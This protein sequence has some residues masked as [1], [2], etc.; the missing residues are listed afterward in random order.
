MHLRRRLLFAGAFACGLLATSPALAVVPDATVDIPSRAAGFTPRTVTVAPDQVVQWVWTGGASDRNHSPA[1][2]AGQAESW[3]SDPGNPKP[4]FDHGA[5]HTFDHAFVKSGSFTYHCKVHADMTG[6]IVVTGAPVPSYTVPSPS[7]AG[8]AV[9]FDASGSTDLDGTIAK[10][11]WDLDGNGTF[12]TD[13]GTTSSATKTYAAPAALTTRLRVTDDRGN[14]RETTRALTIATRAPSASFTVTPG[15]AA[16][17]Q[18]VSLDA[19]A[20]AATA[21]RT[22]ANYAWDLDGNGSFETDGGTTPTFSTSY[23]APGPKTIGLQVTDSAGDATATTR[24]LTVTNALP[25]AAFTI[26][27]AA[28][29]IGA[30]VTFD[31]TGSADT[32]GTIASF[33]WDLDGNGTFETNTGTTPTTSKAYAAAGSVSVK[34]RVTDNDGATTDLAKTVNVP[35]PAA[36]PAPPSPPAASPPAPQAQGPAPLAT[37]PLAAVTPAPASAVRPAPAPAAKAQAKP[38]KKSKKKRKKK[39]KRRKKR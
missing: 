29:A 9:T 16:K 36:P 3:E 5:G 6:T 33:Q 18:A 15:T 13:T 34:L 12:E 22:I 25:T 27:N 30:T 37:A 21:G 1:S 2:D 7:F 14:V 8:D 26:S 24:T 11:E 17:N 38:T 35:A 23:A 20:S 32:D 19:T 28:P 4:D 31:A 10:F 39:A